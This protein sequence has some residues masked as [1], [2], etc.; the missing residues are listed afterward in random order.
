MIKKA[1]LTAIRWYQS[2]GGSKHFFSIDC[3]FTPPCSE[4]THQAI[5]KYGVIKGIKQGYAR[6]RRCNDP[7]CVLIIHDPID[8]DDI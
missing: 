3:N 1:I 2:K 6:I 7:D 8:K 5:E 4:Y